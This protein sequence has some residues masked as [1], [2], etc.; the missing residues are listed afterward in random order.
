LQPASSNNEGGEGEGEGNGGD[1]GQCQ[2]RR[3][4]CHLAAWQS[5]MEH[6][7]G[8][9]VAC[10]HI[11][12]CGQPSRHVSFKNAGRGRLAAVS[13]WLAVVTNMRVSVHQNPF[14]TSGD[15]QIRSD[16]YM[17]D[18]LISHSLLQR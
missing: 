18:Y 7:D 2:C 4:G 13:T 10:F 3:Q 12:R 17:A 6:I 16:T 11:A 5:L 8:V 9:L 15:A 14:E 1:G